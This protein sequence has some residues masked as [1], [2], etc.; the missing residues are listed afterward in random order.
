M[1]AVVRG[2]FQ[3]DQGAEPLAEVPVDLA[4]EFGCRRMVLAR[5]TFPDGGDADRVA[6]CDSGEDRVSDA[7]V[8]GGAVFSCDPFG[9][10]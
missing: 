7:H 10:L 5:V 9:G 6:G 2:C 8:D 1:I 4:E 3:P